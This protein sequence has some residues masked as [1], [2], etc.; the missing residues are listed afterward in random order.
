MH[1][2]VRLCVASMHVRCACSAGAALGR[3][4]DWVNKRSSGAHSSCQHW[5]GSTWSTWWRWG[6]QWRIVTKILRVLWMTTMKTLPSNQMSQ[7]VAFFIFFE[8]VFSDSASSVLFIHQWIADISREQ[9]KQSVT[10]AISRTMTEANLCFAMLL[11]EHS[12][13]FAWQGHGNNTTRDVCISQMGGEGAL[14]CKQLETAGKSDWCLGRCVE[15]SQIARCYLGKILS[16]NVQCTFCSSLGN[17]LT[18]ITKI[19]VLL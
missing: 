10:K 7:T 5:W 11:T 6:K 16:H 14:H 9:R 8:F 17:S 19:E 18:I 4:K 1:S 2:F 13:R 15:R 3:R 12:L